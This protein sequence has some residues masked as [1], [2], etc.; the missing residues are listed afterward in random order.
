MKG[1]HREEI[2]LNEPSIT[3]HT[4]EE[5]TETREYCFA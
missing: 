1:G 4:W 3:E 5:K 2:D